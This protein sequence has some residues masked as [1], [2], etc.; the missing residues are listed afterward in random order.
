MRIGIIAVFTDYHRRGRHHRG[1]LQPQIGPLIAALL[2]NDVDIHVVNDTWDDPDW[3]RHYDLLFLSCLHSDFDRARQISHYWRRRGAKTVLGGYFASS[4]PD[5]CAGHFDAIAIGDPETTVPR[6]WNDFRLGQLQPR[7]VAG[8]Y[9]PATT[10]TPRFELAAHQQILPIGIETS[11]GCP[12]R[13]DFC[14]LTGLGRRY[15]NRPPEAVARDIVAGQRACGRF[16]FW[17]RRNIVAVYDNNIGGGRRQL[18]HLCDALAPLGVHW[19]VCA[20]FN[21]LCDDELLAHLARAGCR[22]LFVGL[23]SFNPAAISD[24]GKVQN[25][26]PE[27]RSAVERCHRH[28][29]IV[30]A[31]LMLNPAMDDIPY[32][33]SIPERLRDSG[34]HVPT[35]VCFETP[36]PGTPHFDR[37]VAQKE[38]AFLPNALLRDFNG[39]T[40]VTRPKHA[41]GEEFVAAYK[42]LVGRV[43]SPTARLAKLFRD[44]R[45]FVG[46]GHWLPMLFDAS[47]L[48][49]ES[50]RFS[51]KRTFLAGS[52]IP[53]PEYGRIPFAATDFAST[54]EREAILAPLRVTD[55]NGRVLPI[56]LDTRRL[57]LPSDHI[58]SLE[59]ANSKQSGD[60]KLS[61]QADGGYVMKDRT[62][63]S[64]QAALLP[65]FP[66]ANAPAPHD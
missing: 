50:G 2:P 35:Y 9:D 1:V 40:L 12:H 6:I 34:L 13:C 27:V 57:G 21:I 45:S 18:R 51:A 7:Y 56:W 26:L 62:K 38:P 61:V 65:A 8:R 19:G 29:I 4:H 42:R 16:A 39:Y 55:R 41:T 36:F 64:I 23:E 48:A 54:S 20:S 14:V 63:A 58:A 49:S 32:I 30:M 5:L 25:L 52:D 11:R 24:M 66:M 28:G 44:A 10:P 43:F 3:S 59:Q 37:L 17:H 60:P 33:E 46:R 22:G 53:P 15:H 31:G 47:E